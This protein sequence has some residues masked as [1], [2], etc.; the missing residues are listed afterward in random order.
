ML[1]YSMLSDYILLYYH[2]ILQ[3][4]TDGRIRKKRKPTVHKNVTDIVSLKNIGFFTFY[5]LIR[6]L[7]YFFNFSF[8]LYYTCFNTYHNY[9]KTSTKHATKQ[10]TQN[11]KKL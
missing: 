9:S 2:S 5:L 8:K 11:A 6:T 4:E 3:I 10:L 7:D 1:I